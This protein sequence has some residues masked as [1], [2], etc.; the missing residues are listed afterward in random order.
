MTNDSIKIAW[1]DFLTHP[2]YAFVVGIYEGALLYSYGAYRATVNSIMLGT[3]G[4]N[5]P[6]R[7]AIYKH[8][9]EAAG[10]A[11]SFETFLEY[12][13]KN[14]TAV[15]SKSSSTTPTKPVDKRRLGAPPVF[16]NR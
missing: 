11:Y 6:S 16:L 13:K 2:D 3:G 10:E 8:I 12:D 15:R 9:M 7:W 5:A 14:L 4:F 1:K